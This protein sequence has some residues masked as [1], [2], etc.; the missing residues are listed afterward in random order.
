MPR[1]GERPSLA[2]SDGYAV[3]QMLDGVTTL[4]CCIGI[5]LLAVLLNADGA[6]H[7]SWCY[8]RINGVPPIQE[9]WLGRCAR[10]RAQRAARRALRRLARR[11]ASQSGD[12]ICQG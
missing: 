9:A 2:I 5:R 11:L 6:V 12:A 3:V 1:M 4:R 7:A 10:E 8:A